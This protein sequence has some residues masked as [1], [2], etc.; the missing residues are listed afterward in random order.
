MSGQTNGQS[1]GRKPPV[2][3]NLD[4]EFRRVSLTNDEAARTLEVPER[5]IRRWRKG[6]VTPSWRNL[7]R[8]A[9]LFGREP[10]WFYV[11]RVD[12]NDDPEP[13]PEAA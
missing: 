5:A 6:V 11:D 7:C 10:G 8:L 9:V 2:A 1:G 4:S 3:G 13:A 12:E